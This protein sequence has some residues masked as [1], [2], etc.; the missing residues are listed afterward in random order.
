MESMDKFARHELKF[1]L[2]AQGAGSVREWAL[3]HLELDE[4]VPGDSS[5]YHLQTLYFDNPAFDVFHRNLPDRGTKYRIRRY[6]SEDVVYLERKRR[7]GTVVTKRRSSWPL[8]RLSEVVKA[9]P[10][11]DGWP[12]GF[13]RRISTHSLS[14][15]AMMNYRRY[16]FVGE[17]SSRLTIDDQI[18]SGKVDAVDRFE[19][20]SEKVSTGKQTVLELK[21]D[22]DMP[23]R[24]VDLMSELGQ[25]PVGFSKY[26]RGVI[27]L[28]LAVATPGVLNG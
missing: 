19:S 25:D 18:S 13:Q 4:H 24:F 2:D 8:A 12:G 27:A 6:G 28:G 5:C 3:E 14:P 1:V 26:A 22:G 20:E 16:A 11:L 10:S 17:G 7:Q 21:F 9:E 23:T 15:V